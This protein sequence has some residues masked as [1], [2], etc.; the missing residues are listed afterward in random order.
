M[1]TTHQHRNNHSALRRGFTL[2]ELLVA[3][4]I[5]SM[6]VLIIMQMTSKGL[7]IWKTVTDEVATSSRARVA[8]RTIAN[9]F[10]SIQMRLGDNKYE[11][12]FAKGD[13]EA[14]NALKGMKIPYTTRCVF[15]T[16]AFD[17]NPAV[18]SSDSL[19]SNYRSARAHNAD[20]QGDVNAVGYRLLYRDQILNVP[21]SSRKGSSQGA[22][23]LFSLYRQLISPRDAYEKIMAKESLEAAYIP[24]E[25][26]DKK[27]FICENNIEFNLVLTIAYAS[28]KSG[29]SNRTYY[30]HVTVPVISSKTS[31]SSI[32]IFGDRIEVGGKSLEN[33]HI[34]SANVS[35][36]VVTEE[37][38][39]VINQIR[40]GRRP[41]EKIDTFLQK[42]TRTYARRIAPPMAL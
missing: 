18:G 30:E 7:E 42:Y 39:N 19:R 9:D 25:R 23:P 41:A 40:L 38:M 35:V 33:A 8:L 21:A 32:R 13:N 3:M 14:S 10:E 11:W 28:G 29:N 36:T 37:G 5:T 20:T 6:L 17:R 26:D 31:Q 2:L 15:F 4:V 22:F 34:A 1:K 24:F 12:F 27:N 16:S